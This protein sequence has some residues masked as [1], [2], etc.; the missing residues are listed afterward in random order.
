MEEQGKL[1]VRGLTAGLLGVILS[2]GITWAGPAFDPHTAEGG[3]PQ[4]KADLATCTA[5][6]TRTQPKYDACL[7]DLEDCT[8]NLSAC[9]AELGACV[10]TTR[11]QRTG[12]TEKYGPGDD[13]ALQMGVMWPSPRFTTNNNGTVAD[14]FTGLIWTQNANLFSQQN[15]NGALTSCNSLGS[16]TYGLSDGSKAG[17]WRLPN[18]RELQSLIDYGRL[19]P[20]LPV[21]HPFANVQPFYYWSSTTYAG[22]PGNAWF[23]SLNNGSTAKDGKGYSYSIFVWCV[24]GGQ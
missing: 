19:S 20:A 23:V 10:Q 1:V 14:N 3:L 17:D 13:E 6:L 9:E 12:E 21:G 2:A 16:G 22:Y 8:A 7:N 18:V 24:R 5:G 11:V 15:W 4:C